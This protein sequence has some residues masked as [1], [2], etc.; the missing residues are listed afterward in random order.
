M[1]AVN[2]DQ[3]IVGA[4]AG[5]VAALVPLA[6]PQVRTLPRRTAASSIVRWVPQS[7]TN[8]HSEPRTGRRAVSFQKRW[9]VGSAT[10]RALR[11]LGGC[12]LL[13]RSRSG[14]LTI[15]ASTRKR[16]ATAD[17]LRVNIDLS[18]A[19]ADASPFLALG[20]ALQR[21]AAGARARG[22]FVHDW[23][24]WRFCLRNGLGLACRRDGSSNLRRRR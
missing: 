23:R 1:V 6:C 15:L 3:L 2:A 11:L 14:F 8:R 10:W 24:G 22:Q 19:V 20:F 5:S 9:P 4:L 7:Q 21:E 17:H 12:R 18:A 13:P 16:L